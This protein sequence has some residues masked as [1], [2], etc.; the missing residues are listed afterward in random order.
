MNLLALPLD[1]L[2]ANVAGIFVCACIVVV[3]VC[4]LEFH[5]SMRWRMTLTQIML[6]AFAFWAAGTGVDLWRGGNI[7][8][9][10]AAAG[11]GILV[12]LWISYPEQCEREE[13]QKTSQAL[14]CRSVR[15]DTVTRAGPYNEHYLHAE[16]THAHPLN[17]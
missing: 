6:I 11:L 9:H 5:E 14:A 17:R 1:H 15:R 16:D 7:G 10:G 13:A 3:C 8:F 4:R 2:A 12:Y